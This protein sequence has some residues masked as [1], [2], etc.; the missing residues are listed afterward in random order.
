MRHRWKKTQ[1]WSVGKAFPSTGAVSV[2]GQEAGLSSSPLH[3]YFHALKEFL[4]TCKIHLS[5][6]ALLAFNNKI[7]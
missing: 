2:G 6:T 4:R 1:G 3:C 5:V 7:V